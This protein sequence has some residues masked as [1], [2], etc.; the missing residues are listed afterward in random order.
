[1]WLLKKL[2]KDKENKYLNLIKYYVEK[3]IE[4]YSPHRND[5]GKYLKEHLDV[6][7][8]GHP[9][10]LYKLSEDLILKIFKKRNRYDEWKIIKQSRKKSSKTLSKL[11][12]YEFIEKIFDYNS[13]MKLKINKNSEEEENVS[14]KVAKIIGVPVCVYCNRQYIFTVNKKDNTKKGITRPQFDHYLPKSIYPF[15]A[16]S[17]YNLI[18]S[19]SIC[20]SLKSDKDINRIESIKDKNFEDIKMNPYIKKGEIDDLFKFSYYPNKY[21]EP[22]EIKIIQTRNKDYKKKV[23]AFLELFKI[24]E[25]YSA[26]AGFEVKDLYNFATKYSDTYLQS[27]LEQ[28]GLYYRLSQEDAYRLLFGTELYSKNDNNRPLSKLKRDLLEE[29][30]IIH[31]K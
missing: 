5:I 30:G 2:S 1:M 19:C 12:R 13:I 16:L 29:F 21:G 26:H 18:P 14:Y 31:K 10:D 6:L 11:K 25:I 22:E 28:I 24:E 9:Q 27:L 15:F 7:L 20:N 8:L 23:E 17:L 3:N 4:R